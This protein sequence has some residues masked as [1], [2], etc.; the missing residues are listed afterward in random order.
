M[1]ELLVMKHRLGV[2]LLVAAVA[3]AVVF[4]L[5]ALAEELLK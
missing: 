1:K 2:M 3:L 5:P 4:A